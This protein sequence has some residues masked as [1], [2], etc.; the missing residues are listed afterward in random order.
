VYAES[1]P[2]IL[3]WKL[4]SGGLA[5]EGRPDTIV[6]GL[7][8]KGG[9]TMHPFVISPSGDLFVD[10]GSATNACQVQDRTAG[11]PGERPC[12]ELEGRAGIWHFTAEQTGQR[13]SPGARYAT[14][15][16]NAE[17][18]A[19]HPGDG[20]LFAT[21]HGRDQLLQDWPKL[22]TAKESADLPAEE[23]LRVQR[24]GTT[25]GPTAT[26]TRHRTRRCSRPSMVATR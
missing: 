25:A 23:L 16:R 3:R 11:S 9:H 1:G 15:I 24:G 17:G 12:K 6:T 20:A 18:F 13:Y 14:G 10:V 21:Q 22:F 5:P 4:P 19:I 8:I 26:T 2:T 7:P